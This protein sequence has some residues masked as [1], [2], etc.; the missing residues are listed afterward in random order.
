MAEIVKLAIL[1]LEGDC[2]T[3]S[4]RVRL[5][6]G[7]EDARPTVQVRGTLP[8]NPALMATLDQWRD[9]YHSL[10]QPNRTIK[11]QTILYDGSIYID[12]CRRAAQSLKQQFQA[13]LGTPSFRVIDERLREEL[14]RQELIRVLIRTDHPELQCLPWHSWSFIDRYCRAEIGLS[15]LSTLQSLE[16][17]KSNRRQVR[18]LAILG[19]SS[20]I[21]T[22]EDARLLQTL[23]GATVEVLLQPE[24]SQMSHQLWDQSWDILFFAGH[25]KTENSKGRIYLNPQESLSLEELKY[26][27]RRAIANGLQLAIFNSCDG[28]GLAYELDEVGLPYMIVMREPIPDPV[29]Q[30]FL[31]GFLNAFSQG[32]SLFEATREARERLEGVEGNYPCASWLP[33]VYQ[34]PSRPKLYWHTLQGK[35]DSDPNPVS[36]TPLPISST[37]RWRDKIQP[38]FVTLVVTSLIIGLRM[39]GILQPLELKA[40]DHLLRAQPEFYEQ[41][42]RIVV[43][44][45]NQGAID[46]QEEVDLKEADRSLSDGALLQLLETVEP[47]Q[48]AVIGFDIIHDYAFSPELLA[49]FEK[50]DQFIAICRSSIYKSDL[51]GKTP[52]PNL[53]IQKIGFS[54]FPIDSDS[55]LRRQLFGMDQTIICPADKSFS[56]QVALGYLSHITGRTVEWNLRGDYVE[57]EGTTFKKIEPTTGGYQLSAKN[58]E[59]FQI[60]TNFRRSNPNKIFLEEILLMADREPQ[61]LRE[62]IEGKIIFIGVTIPKEDDHKTPYTLDATASEPGIMVHARM[63]NS[64]LNS[65]LDNQS[66][67]YWWPDYIE[68][69]WI[70]LWALV[71]CIFAGLFQNKILVFMASIFLIGMQYFICWYSL[72]IGFWIPLIPVNLSIIIAISL[73]SQLNPR[74]NAIV[75]R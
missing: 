7:P 51:P 23:P 34:N 74:M 22:E 19:H 45:V 56:F 46:Y 72:S 4:V 20:G 38:V 53:S 32:Q 5:E 44:A 28:L 75:D 37:L 24:R 50:N 13:W 1:E 52:P 18:I 71:G 67:I 30:S 57:I 17:P 54:N 55:V 60:L 43:V 6:I 49:Y 14:G 11:P 62:K 66:P 41:N 70:A 58:S 21:K 12:N 69:L 73:M 59:G 61:K 40:Y 48:P 3:E 47:Y 15:S 42:D 39:L 25:S 27:L 63:T 10:G 64:I 2:R 8:P 16:S 31:K 9:R 26:G 68:M 29:A 33:I 65:V 35:I 36:Q